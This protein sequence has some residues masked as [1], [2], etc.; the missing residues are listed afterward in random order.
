V[1][2]PGGGGH[3]LIVVGITPIHLIV[4]DPFGEADLVNGTTL[5]G[6]ARFCRYSRRNFERRWMVEGEGSGWAVITKG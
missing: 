3:W 2:R 6:I 4:H 5:G 1:S